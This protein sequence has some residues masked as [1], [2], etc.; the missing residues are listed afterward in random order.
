MKTAKLLI[1]FFLLSFFSACV[2][3]EEVIVIHADHSGEYT[4]VMDMSKLIG[5]T[6]QMGTDENNNGSKLE[7][8]DS[9]VV[10]KDLVLAADN[11]SAEE[12]ELYKE[13]SI[14]IKLNKPNAEMKIIMTCPFNL[15]SH[16]P[17]IKNN[18][19]LVMNKIKAFDNLS[20]KQEKDTEPP[21]DAGMAEKALMPGTSYFQ[22]TAVPGQLESKMIDSM[23]FRKLMSADSTI[24]MMQQMAGM[25]GEM[26][27]KT[28]ISTA[29]E[30]KNYKG[31]NAVLSADKKTITFISSFT[32]MIEHP[33]KLAYKVEY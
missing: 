24:L 3:T 12:K 22:F 29:G 11:L 18:F 28:R 17:E 14:R 7:I 23:N 9:T 6:N 26:T 13:A 31:N 27:Y 19:Y 21:V 16:L 15:I 8:I 30:I 2:D 25:M 32:D 10:L 4:L 33:E 20:N 1:A 5:L